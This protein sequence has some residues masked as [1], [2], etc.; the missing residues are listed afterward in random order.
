MEAL[1]NSSESEAALLA[2]CVLLHALYRARKRDP[3]LVECREGVT[4]P[5]QWQTRE[6]RLFLKAIHLIAGAHHDPKLNVG[7]VAAGCHVSRSFL[8][9]VFR[10]I[11]GHG[12]W[13]YVQEYRIDRARELIHQDSC[14]FS[15]IA[16]RIGFPDIFTFSRVFKR[17]AGEPPSHYRKRILQANMPRET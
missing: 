17:V 14:T 1:W 11:V 8:D 15:Q 9:Q 7:D 16:D 12:P 3:V 10:R 2:E 5:V 4:V 13:R 6:Y